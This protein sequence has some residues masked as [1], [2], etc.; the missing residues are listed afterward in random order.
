MVLPTIITEGI[1]GKQ[2]QSYD[3]HV[4]DFSSTVSGRPPFLRTT[5]GGGKVKNNIMQINGKKGEIFFLH[6]GSSLVSRGFA[7][8]PFHVLTFYHVLKEKV[9]DYSW[10]RF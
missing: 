8:H 1:V 5:P 7:P 9:G 6:L 10:S 3:M 2:F 4:C